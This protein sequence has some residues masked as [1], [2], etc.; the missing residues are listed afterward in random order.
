MRNLRI[1]KLANNETPVLPNTFLQ[2]SYETYLQRFIE[3][4]ISNE[5]IGGKCR[6]L[7]FVTH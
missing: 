5:E 3:G 2:E 7:I 1:N 6:F 4:V